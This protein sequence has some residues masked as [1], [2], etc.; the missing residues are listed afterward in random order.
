VRVS[1][2]VSEGGEGKSHPIFETAAP[3]KKR[4]EERNKD[5]SEWGMLRII[6]RGKSELLDAEQ[7]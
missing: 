1:F 2:L 4:R 7:N 5:N 6:K 3:I